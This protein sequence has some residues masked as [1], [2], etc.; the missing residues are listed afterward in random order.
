M[1]AAACGAK[2]VEVLSPE[3][4]TARVVDR[5]TI[6][7]LKTFE[8]PVMRTTT[9]SPPAGK[10]GNVTQGAI[11]ST[12]RYETGLVIEQVISRLP[13]NQLTAQ[14]ISGQKLTTENLADAFRKPQR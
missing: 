12:T 3:I 7:L 9:V 10:P 6:E 4:A 5:Q 8:R 13:I 11:K 1:I 2:S 14:R